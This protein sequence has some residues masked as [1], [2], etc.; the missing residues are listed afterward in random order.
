MSHLRRA[1]CSTQKF[2][3]VHGSVAAA[4]TTARNGYGPTYAPCDGRRCVNPEGGALTIVAVYVHEQYSV[5]VD[6]RIELMHDV[7]RS[8]SILPPDMPSL[9]AFPA[10][11][12]GFDAAAYANDDQ[13]IAWWNPNPREIEGKPF[14][15]GA[16]IAFGVDSRAR[17]T[18]ARA[19][20]KLLYLLRALTNTADDA[21]RDSDT[22]C[23]RHTSF[24]PL[25]MPSDDAMGLHEQDVE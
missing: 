14:P 12:F 21:T 19:A 15:V 25:P 9:W 6:A 1:T 4:R 24:A 8:E 17:A 3:F 18:T 11:N 10:G 22:A 5:N 16:W 13:H 7:A 2:P 20:P 23:E